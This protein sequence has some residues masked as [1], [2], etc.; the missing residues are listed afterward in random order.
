M[1]DTSLS[2]RLRHLLITEDRL[3]G[4]KLMPWRNGSQTSLADG[5]AEES[6]SGSR[7]S[8]A[9]MSDGDAESEKGLSQNVPSLLT[10]HANGTSFPSPAISP[11]TVIFEVSPHNQDRPLPIDISAARQYPFP[12]ISSS[13]SNRPTSSI[14]S[15]LNSQPVVSPPSSASSNGSLPSSSS[16]RPENGRDKERERRTSNYNSN[17]GTSI[18]SSEHE[19]GK[20]KTSLP[21][22]RPAISPT[23]GSLLSPSSEYF[24]APQTAPIIHHRQSMYFDARSPGAHQHQHPLPVDKRDFRLPGPGASSDGFGTDGRPGLLRRHS[25]HPYEYPS[26]TEQQ[27]QR[28]TTA[29]A[30]G[31]IYEIDYAGMGARA[32]ISRTTKACN[33]CRNRKVRCDAGGGEMGPCSRC[34]E[35]GTQCVYTGVQ[36]KRGP[37]PGTARPSISKPRRP[38]SQSQISSHRS[39]VASVQSVQ[40]YV[41]TPTDEQAPWSRSS[42]GF[43]PHHPSFSSAASYS[44]PHSSGCGNGPP[45]DSSEWSSVAPG[46]TRSNLLPHRGSVS[47]G[48]LMNG[49]GTSIVSWSPSFEQPPSALLSDGNANRNIQESLRSSSNLNSS[50]MFDRNYALGPRN[51]IVKSD[52]AG[53]HLPDT[54]MIQPRTLPPLKVAIDGGHNYEA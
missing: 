48:P 23:S 47:G 25:S 34:V 39:S 32:P 10:T 46:K 42:Y 49:N 53:S 54:R 19:K 24:S 31:P 44:H 51:S 20:R 43:P 26:H 35:S 1:Q 30:T 13:T 5:R 38:S 7:R 36:K 15:L 12:S 27:Q 37:C 9:S 50:S 22:A 40:S 52:G 6:G 17:S 21:Y 18:R 11:T 3:T 33:A 29:Y 16:L 45:P 28:P 4:N 8:L 2:P 14:F 41:I